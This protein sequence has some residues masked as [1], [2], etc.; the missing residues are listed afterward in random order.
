MAVSILFLKLFSF[1]CLTFPLPTILFLIFFTIIAPFFSSFNYLFYL[2]YFFLLL[3]KLL[4]VLSPLKPLVFSLRALRLLLEVLVFNIFFLLLVDVSTRV[5]MEFAIE[6]PMVEI[7]FEFLEE[8][9]VDF[10]SLVLSCELEQLR[11]V[12]VARFVAFRIIK[13]T[14]I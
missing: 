1:S 13:L 6:L 3:T 4:E 5:L 7:L 11:I 8:A 14:N 12:L 2:S 10:L 9:E